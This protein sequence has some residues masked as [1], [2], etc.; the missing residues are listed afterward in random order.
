MR[1]KMKEYYQGA[2]VSAV[3]VHTGATVNT[4]EPNEVYEVEAQLGAELLKHRKAVDVAQPHYG[5]QVESELRNDIERHKAQAGET[6]QEFESLSAADDDNKKVS[7]P[8][9]TSKKIKRG[10]K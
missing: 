1:I 10:G 3:L 9:M 7:E 2:G 4:L 6:A 5:A 8:V